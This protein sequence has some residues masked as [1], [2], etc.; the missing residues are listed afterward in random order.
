MEGTSGVVNKVPFLNLGGV[1]LTVIHQATRV[2]DVVSVCV[3]LYNKKIKTKDSHLIQAQ[4]P[5]PLSNGLPKAMRKR[6]QHTMMRMHRRQPI[7]L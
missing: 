2:I 4:V 1:H 6:I 5:M 7:L 3:S